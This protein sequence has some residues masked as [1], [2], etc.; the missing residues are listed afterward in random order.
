M[1]RQGRAAARRRRPRDTAHERRP[2]VVERRVVL[3]ARGRGARGGRRVGLGQDDRRRWPSWGTPAAGCGSARARCSSTGRTC[4]RCARTTC[5]SCAGRR[6]PTSPRT[7]PRPSTPRCK[8]GTQLAEV[9]TV[10]PRRGR[11]RRRPGSSRCSP[12]RAS[13]ATAEM[14]RRYPHQLS[15]GQQQR[16]AIA[17]AFAVPPV[18]HRARRAD[19]R[20]RRLDASATSSRPSGASAASYGVAAVYVSHDLAV[21]GGLVS[22][23]R[24]DVR[25]AGHRARRDPRRS[26]ARRSTRTR[27]GCWRRSPSPDRAEV[28]TGIDG[29]PAAPRPAAG[30]LLLR[31]ALLVRGRAMPGRDAA[32]RRWSTR[33]L[34]R[35]HRATEIEYAERERVEIGALDPSAEDPAVR[36]PTGSRPPTAASRRARGRRPRRAARALRGG[37]RRVRVGQDDARSLHRRAALELDRRDRVLRRRRWRTGRRRGPRTCCGGS[38]TSSRTPTPRSTRGRP[39]GRSSRSRSSTSSAGLARACRA[40][41]RRCSTRSRSAGTSWAATPTSSRAASASAW[42]SRA[43]SSSSRTLLVCDEV[44]SALDVSVQA[45]IVELLRRLQREQH[46]VDDLHHPQPRASCAPSPRSAVVLCD[47]RVVESGTVDQIL[48]H[49]SDPYTIRLIEDVPKL[50][51]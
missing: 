51:V 32:A 16:F 41:G 49:P 30:R 2:E 37:R 3:G 17:M 14:L 43:R 29:Q 27:G 19:D 22:S 50:A 26:S 28:L 39:S 13:T 4:S 40:R 11:R 36:H 18:A 25:R 12:R 44:T 38:S 21:V 33:S 34:V 45:V 35:C 15:G 1:R 9:L 7:R 42:P 31:A 48:E 10:A 46:L 6:S 24:R 20:A 8:I 23:G 47:G 5:A